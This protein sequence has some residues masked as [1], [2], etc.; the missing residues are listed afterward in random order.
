VVPLV[1]GTLLLV[2]PLVYYSLKTD[3]AYS[4]TFLEFLPR[5]YNVELAFDFPMFLTGAPPD[6]LFTIAHLYFLEYLFVYK[7]VLLPLWLVLRR[8][9]GRRLVDRFGEFCTLRWAVYL[10]ALPIALI[11]AALGTEFAGGWNRYA[12]IPF[13]IYG[14]LMAAEPRIGRSFHRHRRSAL[15]LGL[16]TLLLYYAGSYMLGPAVQFDPQTQ[17][18]AASVLFRAL[19]GITSWFWVILIMGLAIGVGR[20]RPVAKKEP[21]RDSLAESPAPACEPSFMARVSAYAGEAQLPFYVLHMT[22]IISVGFYVVQWQVNALIKYVVIVLATLVIT[23]VVYDIAVRR[24]RLARFL[25]GM[26][27]RPTSSEAKA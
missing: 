4:E 2:P 20:K 13:L 10:L 26:K 18:D 6:E 23:L 19:K 17:Y 16:L 15:V 11:E 3:P 14:F 1:T 24:T 5:F 25:F 7:L 22:P 12:Y 21:V 8:P 27:A 9:A